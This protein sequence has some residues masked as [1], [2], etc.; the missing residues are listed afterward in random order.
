MRKLTLLTIILITLC[1]QARRVFEVPVWE[2]PENSPGGSYTPMMYCYLPDNPNG[3]TILM[4]PGGGYQSVALEEE[5]TAMADWFNE[6]GI[7]Y[8]V[9]K[10]R[11]PQDLVNYPKADAQHAMLRIRASASEWSIDPKKVGIMGASAG[12]HLASSVATFPDHENMRPN[13]QILLYP[14]ITMDIKFT[15]KM[16]RQNLLGRYPSPLQVERYSTDRRV[17]SRTPQCFIAL[18]ADDPRVSPENAWLYFSAL[19]R[20]NIPAT[21]HI[22]P[23]GGHGWGFRDGFLYKPE[24]TA[25]LSKWLRSGLVFPQ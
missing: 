19:R 23:T 12:G 11:L 25:E 14:V 21:L 6:Q 7:T 22:Y 18:S 1:A 2:H 15:G 24:W 16:T 9:L 13:F 4:C 5:G 8:V 10:Y 3:I 20:H 17:D